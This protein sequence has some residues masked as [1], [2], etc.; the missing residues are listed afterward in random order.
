M[1]E[2]TIHTGLAGDNDKV[3]I[4]WFDENG[5]HHKTILDLK[6][7]DQDKP[8]ILEIW[9]NGLKLCETRGD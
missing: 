5:V 8:R 6:I 9:C 7:K 1:S 2:I 3:N 4:D